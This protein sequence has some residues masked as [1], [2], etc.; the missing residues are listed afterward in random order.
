MGMVIDCPPLA[1]K[2]GAVVDRDLAPENA[3]RIALD[4]SGKVTWVAGQEVRR[5]APARDE[6]QRREEMIHI[7]L[8]AD[9]Y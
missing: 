3:W 9:L 7:L 8:P 1:A 5:T 4:G 2:L 6:G